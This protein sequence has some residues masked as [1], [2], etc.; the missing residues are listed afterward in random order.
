MWPEPAQTVDECP[1]SG[2]RFI[3]REYS[4]SLAVQNRTNQPGIALILTGAAQQ[5]NGHG[6]QTFERINGLK[7]VP[8]GGRF[9]VGLGAGE[10]K[11]SQRTFCLLLTHWVR[12]AGDAE[13]QP[14]DVIEGPA[15]IVVQGG[16]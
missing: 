1:E 15:V 8:V 16:R 14:S 12:D 9:G 13:R 2:L 3:E 4:E 6:V 7:H 11:H 5:E 10:H